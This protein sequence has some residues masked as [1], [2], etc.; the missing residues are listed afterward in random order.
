MCP[1]DRQQDNVVV[2]CHDRKGKT[3]GEIVL[4][5]LEGLGNTADKFEESIKKLEKYHDSIRKD[6]TDLDAMWEGPAH[7]QFKRDW[8]T[9]LAEYK[10]LIDQYK[11]LLEYERK[12]YSEYV[13]ATDRADEIIKN[14][15]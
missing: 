7:E 15:K 6:V 9:C 13:K 4:C 5:Y 12:A 10:N 1:D 8:N 2:E 11:R 3:M 14:L